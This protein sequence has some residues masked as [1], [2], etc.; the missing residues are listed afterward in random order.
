MSQLAETKG[1]CSIQN[2]SITWIMV[3]PPPNINSNNVYKMQLDRKLTPGILL[4][5]ITHILNHK[6]PSELLIPLHNISNKEIKIPKT[7]F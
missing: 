1:Q 4:L 6:H 5:D 2:R 3:K 7:L